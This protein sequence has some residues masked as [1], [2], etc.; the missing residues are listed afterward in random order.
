MLHR[1]FKALPAPTPPAS[2]PKPT[3]E[4]RPRAIA[5]DE[6]NGKPPLGESGD[7]NLKRKAELPDENGLSG[8]K[9]ARKLF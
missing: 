4:L 3:A 2:L 7:G 9:V 5:P 1:Y 6:V 8:R